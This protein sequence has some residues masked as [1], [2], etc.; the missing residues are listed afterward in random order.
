MKR[1]IRNKSKRWHLI[2]NKGSMHQ[3]YLTFSNIYEVYK[4]PV[5]PKRDINSRTIV[6]GD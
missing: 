1:I 5:N 4:V 6:I 2:M 3:E